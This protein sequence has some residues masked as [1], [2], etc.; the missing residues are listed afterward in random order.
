[1][2]IPQTPLPENIK[3]FKC[4]HIKQIPFSSKN[5]KFSHFDSQMLAFLRHISPLFTGVN[6]NLLSFGPK[7]DLA[8]LRTLFD[9]LAPLIHGIHSMAIDRCVIPLVDQYLAPK[10]AQTNRLTIIIDDQIPQA[11]IDFAMNWLASDGRRDHAKP[12]LL[13]IFTESNVFQ[14]ISTAVQTVLV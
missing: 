10:L 5:T 8:N 12:R 4:L 11:G 14:Q 9:H 2:T 6:L 1:M 7:D 13:K 3:F